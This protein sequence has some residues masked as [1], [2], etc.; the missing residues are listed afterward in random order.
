MCKGKM[1][2]KIN[3]C[4]DNLQ[5]LIL[6]HSLIT[7]RPLFNET[8]FRICGIFYVNQKRAEHAVALIIKPKRWVAS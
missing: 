6:D 8:K 7:I 5:G 4:Q 1:E 2:I 3:T